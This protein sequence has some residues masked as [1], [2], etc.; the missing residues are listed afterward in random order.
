MI[1]SENGATLIVWFEVFFHHNSVFQLA[2]SVLFLEA[3]GVVV[4]FLLAED[5]LNA[6]SIYFGIYVNYYYHI[7]YLFFHLHWKKKPISELQAFTLRIA[8]D[9]PL[10]LR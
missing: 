3:G 9:N 8:S 1:A 5:E 4:K 7:Y 2:V 6:F 10:V